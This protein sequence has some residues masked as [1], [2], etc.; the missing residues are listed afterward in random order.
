MNKTCERRFAPPRNT[1][2]LSAR[3][4]LVL[5]GALTLLI[6]S[7]ERNARAQP[8]AA[9]L[10]WSGLTAFRLRLLHHHGRQSLRGARLRACIPLR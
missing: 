1:S 3:G 8:G 4:I 5:S 10:R 6:G 2:R 7:S 9:R